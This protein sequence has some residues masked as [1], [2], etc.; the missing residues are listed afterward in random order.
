M[1]YLL[2]MHSFEIILLLLLSKDHITTLLDVKN[3]VYSLIAL[4]ACVIFCF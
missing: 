2:M 1:E 4:S 3:L